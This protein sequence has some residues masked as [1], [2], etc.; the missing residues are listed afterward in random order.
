MAKA[1]RI[2]NASYLPRA[3]CTWFESESKVCQWNAP[4]G[5]SARDEAKAHAEQ[6]PGHVVDVIS[7]TIDEYKAEA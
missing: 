3:Q 2:A 6:F 1:K 4:S 5:P 7:E